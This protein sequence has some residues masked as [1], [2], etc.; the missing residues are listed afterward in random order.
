[1]ILQPF[2][3]LYHLRNLWLL[4]S[5]FLSSNGPLISR[6]THHPNNNNT[7]T[8]MVTKRED[9]VRV[10]YVWEFTKGRGRERNRRRVVTVM[11]VIIR[12]WDVVTKY[13]EAGG[14]S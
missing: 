1:M 9:N 2:F 5:D 14:F 13:M 8:M 12:T 4:S 6:P 3:Y 11:R 7:S 10:G